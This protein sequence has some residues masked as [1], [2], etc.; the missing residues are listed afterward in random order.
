VSAG[1]LVRELPD[2]GREFV[3]EDPVLRA[4]VVDGGITLRFGRVDVAVTGPCTLEVDGNR[5]RLDPGAP[6]TLAPLL[7]CYPGSARW[8]WASPDGRLT[9]VWMQGQRL[10]VPG[11]PVPCTWSVGGMSGPG[12]GWGPRPQTPGP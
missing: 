10:T 2:G 9:V 5:H 3:L 1:V 4:L 6:D 7:S 12:P 11:P 8:L